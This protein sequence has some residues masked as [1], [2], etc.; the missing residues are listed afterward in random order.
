M[1]PAFKLFAANCDP[2]FFGIPS[3]YHYLYT[4]NKISHSTCMTNTSFKLPDDLLL[5]G[6]GVLDILLRLAGMV[7][8]GFIMYG[9]IQ[10]LTS[11]GSPDKTKHA[12]GTIINALVGMVI[13][14]MAAGAVNYIGTKVAG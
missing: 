5:I 11:E 3:W 14:I 2:K 4:A 10:Y 13:A 6:F 12:Q 8:V 9:G 7:A 1:L